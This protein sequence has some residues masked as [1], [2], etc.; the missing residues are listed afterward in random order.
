MKES[1]YSTIII[2][3]GIS[4]LYAALKIEQQK[5][6]K[7]GILLITKSVLEQ[8]NSYYAQGGMVAVL[9]G[10]KND[11]VDLHVTDTLRAGAGLGEV[12]AI[13]FISKNSNRVVQDLLSF[14]VEF[15]RD[16]F[17]DF[18]LTKEAAHS[19]NRILH[20]GGDATGREMEI[21]LCNAIRKNPKLLITVATT[22]SLLSFPFDFR[23]FDAITNGLQRSNLI[24]LAA[25]PGVGKTSFALNLAQNAAIREKVPTAIFSLEI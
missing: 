18:K 12:E 19:V 20:A 25:R 11:S 17:G 5:K 1:K 6:S 24:I 8:S 14:G 2:G 13:E 9:D 15:D 22:V 21:A 23:Y 10:N 16:E 7:D 3:S 4:G